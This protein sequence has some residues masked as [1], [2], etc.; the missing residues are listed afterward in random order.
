MSDPIPPDGTTGIWKAVRAGSFLQQIG[1]LLAARDVAGGYVYALQTGAEHAN[2]IG[3]VH[4]GV[5]CSLADQAIAMVAWEAAGRTPTVT[6]QMDT[7]F[8]AAAAPGSRIEA[9]ARLTHR[10]GTMMFLEA[11]L[12]D[13]TA[14]LALTTAVFKTS[15]KGAL[16]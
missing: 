16:T 8:I 10:S 11:E 3:L 13:G 9:R 4:G 15:R 1:P 7:R 12:T 5:L 6:V 14:T 2:A